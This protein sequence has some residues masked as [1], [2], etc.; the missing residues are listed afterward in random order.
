MSAVKSQEISRNFTVRETGK[1]DI[2]NKFA[3]EL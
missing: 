2:T 3:D 1:E